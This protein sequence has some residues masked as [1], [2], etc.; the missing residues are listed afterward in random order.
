MVALQGIDLGRTAH[1]APKLSIPSNS[2][3]VAPTGV[4]AARRPCLLFSTSS[5]L[6]P[7]FAHPC[8]GVP[9]A[10]ALR[11]GMIS[12]G[13]RGDVQPFLA[14]GQELQARGHHVAI[15]CPMLCVDLVHDHGIEA[16]GISYD[17]KAAIL[18]PGMQR[19][20]GDGDGSGCVRAVCEA[21]RQQI[22]ETG[23]DPA[24]EVH[25]FMT[26]F[27]ADVL[28]GHPSFVPLIVVAEAFSVPLVNALFMPFL[29][30]RVMQPGWYT[31]SQLEEEGFLNCPLQAHRHL[32]DQYINT[33]ALKQLNEV[34]S[35]WGMQPYK[36][37]SEVQAIYQSAPEANCWSTHMLQAPS[38]LAQ[39]FPLA[40]QTGYLFADAPEHYELPAALLRF[41]ENGQK[42]IYIGFGSLC[43][44]D[45][46]LA[47]EKVLRAL[48][49]AG[50][51]GII[52]GGWGGMNPEHLNP[53]ETPDFAVLKQLL[54]VRL[55]CALQSSPTGVRGDGSLSL[56]LSHR[57]LRFSTSFPLS[58][59]APSRDS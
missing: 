52:C 47:T 26:E 34:R 27:R 57:L 10:M 14:L 39:E 7:S 45:P 15:C 59:S 30:S 24:D 55:A 58:L 13:T 54:G 42:P 46:R 37:C 2:L 23:I 38:D 22:L 25:S 41:L 53:A 36:D 4:A 3:V 21:Q 8:K 49:R 18:S 19:A 20:I 28:V 56:S 12:A 31:Q 50:Q 40:Q 5:C 32:W 1:S 33:D 48:M 35:R 44:G 6:P 17:P 43:V 29:P 16:F 51:R 9:G 11:V